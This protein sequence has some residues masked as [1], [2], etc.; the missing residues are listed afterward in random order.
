VAQIVAKGCFAQMLL[1][2]WDP[3]T[4]SQ[5][6][7]VKATLATLLTF[8]TPTTQQHFVPVIDAVRNG[9]SAAVDDCRVPLWPPAALRASPRVAVAA[10]AA[11][12]SATALLAAVCTFRGLLSG[13]LLDDLVASRLLRG[14]LLPVIELC[15]AQGERGC[16][17]A[18]ATA[19]A[20]AAS[21]AAAL[22]PAWREAGGGGV[23]ELKKLSARAVQLVSSAAAQRVRD[24]AAALRVTLGLP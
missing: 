22:P 9:L 13:A 11:W 3:G 1:H 15:V 23:A 20:R 2:A 18:A 16:A 19:I 5:A 6:A 7:S 14:Q 4:P 24:D 12:R 10:A 8:A 17:F 21:A